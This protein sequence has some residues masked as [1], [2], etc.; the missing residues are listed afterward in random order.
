[1]SKSTSDH[2][3]L[4][5]LL[6][7]QNGLI[8]QVQLGT[9]LEAWTL[10]KSRPLAEH[11]VNR[12]E[13]DAQQRALIEAL[14]SLH[15]KKHGGSVERSLA[16]ISVGPAIRETLAREGESIDP[17]VGHVDSGLGL[18]RDGDVDRTTFHAVGS[19][20]SAGQRF[21]VLRPHAR[22]GLGAVFVALDTEL[23]REVALKTDSRPA[24]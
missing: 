18:T 14:V 3:L 8:N 9:A 6:A 19:T 4:F 13:L 24:R 16:A 21:R 12:G 17:T 11:L 5:G 1:M 20:T 23:H 2:D 7:S 10:D 15:L 22:G